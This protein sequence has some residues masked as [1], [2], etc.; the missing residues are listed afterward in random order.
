MWHLSCSSASD[1]LRVWPTSF[2][3]TWLNSSL[4]QCTVPSGSEPSVSSH[5]SSAMR[6]RE[7]RAANSLDATAF[8]SVGLPFFGG[9]QA[10]NAIPPLRA[11]LVSLAIRNDGRGGWSASFPGFETPYLGA[12]LCKYSELVLSQDSRCQ[13]HVR[14][15]CC[16]V[17]LLITLILI[18]LTSGRRG[19]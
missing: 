5:R 13:P 18:T 2:S 15:A 6:S 3:N 9:F 4:R 17:P 8:D 1:A 10:C 14:C 11:F 19:G 7:A 12:R 16:S